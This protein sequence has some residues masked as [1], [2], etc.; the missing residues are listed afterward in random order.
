MWFAHHFP[1]LNLDIDAL[2]RLTP[3]QTHALRKAGERVLG[4]Q[5][6]VRLGHTRVIAAAAGVRIR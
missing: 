5:E 1:G 3:E 2:D 6:K 4:D